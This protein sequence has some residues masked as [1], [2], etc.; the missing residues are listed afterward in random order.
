MGPP[1]IGIFLT[2]DILPVQA[3]AVGRKV[4]VAVDDV[5]VVEWGREHGAAVIR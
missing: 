5:D 3:H 1:S 2:D 4:M